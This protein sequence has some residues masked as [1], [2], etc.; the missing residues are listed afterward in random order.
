MQFKTTFTIFAV[1]TVFAIL[2][3]L[4]SSL[5]AQ[6]V[7]ES[8]MLALTSELIVLIMSVASMILELR[9]QIF[10]W[11]N[12]MVL[13]I[14]SAN[15]ISSTEDEIFSEKY[16]DV[17][18]QLEELSVGRYRISSINNVYDDDI[19]SIRQLHRGESLYSMCPVPGGVKNAKSQLNNPNL[20]ASM[21]AHY[22]AKEKGVTVHRIYVFEKSNTYSDSSIQEHLKEVKRKGVAVYIILLD[23]PL[24]ID[25]QELPSDFILFGNR[26]VS[27]G[28]IGQGSRVSGGDVFADKQS[29]ETYGREY[30]RL[31]RIALEFED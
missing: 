10:G 3:G 2:L 22:D 18:T 7:Y 25:A 23:D 27:V 21:Q 5:A 6:G 1:G 9:G 20:Q 4:V 16:R 11:L 8:V 24:Q 26:K 17:I 19:R 28:R 29:V 13:L 31:L 30:E 14:R 12:D 15:Y